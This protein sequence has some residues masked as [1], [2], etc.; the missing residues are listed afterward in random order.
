MNKCKLEPLQIEQKMSNDFP[1]AYAL[2][3]LETLHDWILDSMQVDE[4][5]GSI[6]S[7]HLIEVINSLR[8]ASGMPLYVPKVKIGGEDDGH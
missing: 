6:Y 3:K 8:I 1:I 7:R 5:I 4:S 2:G